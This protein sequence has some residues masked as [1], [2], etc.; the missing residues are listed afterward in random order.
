MSDPLVEQDSPLSITASVTGVLTFIVAITATIYVRLS[1]LRHSE[2]EFFR[3]KASLSWFKRESAWMSDLV[4]A[5]GETDRPESGLSRLEYRQSAEYQMY[6]FVMDQIEKLEQRLLDIV[7]ETETR[8][9][10][11]GKAQ[12]FLPHGWS[13]RAET[14]TGN[15]RPKHGAW[16]FVPRGFS[17]KTKTSVAMAWLPVRTRAL[18]LVRERDAL[19]QRVLFTQTSMI[20]S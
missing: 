13:G 1:Y 19:T 12:T 9:A 2:E 14:G 8:S 5:A 18:E 7:T 15:W 16:T 3:V 20:S 17:W 10:N 4:H 6:S 11:T